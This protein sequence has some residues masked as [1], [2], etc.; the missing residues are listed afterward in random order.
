MGDYTTGQ[1]FGAEALF[2]FALVSVV[3]N[4]ATSNDCDGGQF[5][6]ISIGFTVLA[7]ATAVGEIRCVRG[8]V[9]VARAA[10]VPSVWWLA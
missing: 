3:L 8:R 4:V 5:F 2:T 9:G 1:A 6:G 10:C 7:G